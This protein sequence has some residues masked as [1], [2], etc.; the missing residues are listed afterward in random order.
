MLN[1]Y[2]FEL[3]VKQ[4]KNRVLASCLLK[5]HLVTILKIH[6]TSGVDDLNFIKARQLYY[7]YL[8]GA[9]K[10]EYVKVIR[11]VTF[12]V[13]IACLLISLTI[14][15]C[16]TSEPV[17]PDAKSSELPESMGKSGTIKISSTGDALILGCTASVNRQFDSFFMRPAIETL[18]TL[19]ESGMPIPWLATNWHTDPDAKTLTLELREGVKFHDGTNFDAE[20]VKWNLELQIAAGRAELKSIESIDILNDYKVQLNLSRNDSLL[21]INFSSFPG[22]I[23]SPTAYKQNGKDWAVTNPV[24]TGPFKFV[25][26]ERDVKHVF[27]KFDDYWQDDKPYVERLEIHIIADP[28]A[29]IA[30][31]KRGEVDVIIDVP[32]HEAKNFEGD[33]GI[34][35]ITTTMPIRFWGFQPDNA[36]PNSPYYDLKVRQAIWHAVDSEATANA[37]GY[38][39]WK[40]MIQVTLPDCWTY[41]P[42]VKGYP[43]NPEKAKELLTEAGYAEG[44]QTTLIGQTDP[45]HQEFLTI[46]QGYLRNVKIDARIESLEKGAFDELAVGGGTW[47]NALLLRPATVNPSLFA[48]LYRIQGPQGL[49]T[50]GQANEMITPKE[51]QD[52]LEKAATETN[53]DVVQELM[54]QYHYL[55]VDKYALQPFY[56]AETGIAA[57]HDYVQ[58]GGIY[59]VFHTQWKPQDIYIDR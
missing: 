40:P 14:I 25:S 29:Q 55:A 30:A 9:S 47:N 56:V 17:T 2:F 51:I 53:F 13:V 18:T 39:Y 11:R 48:M 26:W 19:D 44:F 12:F 58:G 28:V 37:I 38:G 23:I 3:T 10:M 33:S 41:N 54:Q 32:P 31:F 59:E 6:C 43:Y 24:G 22:M 7:K 45:A 27:E 15:G 52:T 34:E 49:Q 36:K 57:K 35:I 8:R 46:V 20:A 16:T 5:P 4:M 50:L 42:N 21:I 1:I